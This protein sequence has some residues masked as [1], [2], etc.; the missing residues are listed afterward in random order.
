MSSE[1][2]S[3]T[4]DT[5]EFEPDP[6]SGL[7]YEKNPCFCQGD[8]ICVFCLK[9]NENGETKTLEMWCEEDLSPFQFTEEDEIFS[10]KIDYSVN[11]T[12]KQLSMIC[13]YYGLSKGMKR[14]KN[15]ND[16][17]EALVTFES[18]PSN[19]AVVFQRR[20]MWFYLE[21][22]KRDSFMKRFIWTNF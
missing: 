19:S 7:E 5:S 15:K 6:K 8:A 1:N 14:N 16:L 3:L 17:I 20:K 18:D 21:E 4:L 2:I 12:V 22:L 10:K 9:E 13:D 11:F